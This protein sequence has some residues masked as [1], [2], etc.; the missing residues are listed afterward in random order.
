MIGGLVERS[1]GQRGAPARVEHGARES[2]VIHLRRTPERAL[3]AR[4]ARTREV[5]AVFGSL[6]ALQEA[7][8][9]L[10]SN[11][12]DRSQIRRLAAREEGVAAL[13][14]DVALHLHEQISRGG[15]LLWVSLPRPER[16]ATAREILARHARDVRAYMS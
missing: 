5:I 15:I 1:A 16:E 4:T 8:K 7:V 2:K 14:D 11:G 13:R 10:E 6:D 12:F 3:S 9:A